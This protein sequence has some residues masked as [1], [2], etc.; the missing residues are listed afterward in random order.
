[1][2]RRPNI[3]S[4][5]ETRV[6][7]SIQKA[8]RARDVGMNKTKATNVALAPYIT[9]VGRGAPA[10]P[11]PPAVQAWIDEDARQ[12]LRHYRTIARE[13]AELAPERER[14]VKEFFERICGPRGFSVHAGTRRTIPRDELPPR[15][16]RPWRV[17]W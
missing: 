9:C 2:S 15:P 6:E 10:E 11:I 8:R 17:I 12:Q 1:M 13:M 16:R 4:A 7:R 3:V 14:W 5:H